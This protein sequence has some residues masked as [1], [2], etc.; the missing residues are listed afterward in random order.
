MTTMKTGTVWYIGKEYQYVACHRADWFE[1]WQ[2]AIFE[3]AKRLVKAD[4]PGRE[5]KRCF[6]FSDAHKLLP[7]W[8]FI[9]AGA[10]DIVPDH[11]VAAWE[12][13]VQESIQ[14]KL[15]QTPPPVEPEFADIRD[16]EKRNQEL[17]NDLKNKDHDIEALQ[18]QVD[19]AIAMLN[20]E[21]QRVRSLEK[22]VV[23]APREHRGEGFVPRDRNPW[24]KR[25]HR[26][27]VGIAGWED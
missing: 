18:K 10:S 4:N 27:K 12:I 20:V 19:E 7:K 6:G 16:L 17:E 3:E 11:M 26:I 9:V 15:R 1:D 25:R 21:R 24:I 22:L 8:K 13:R 2:G 23:Y 5:I 14:H